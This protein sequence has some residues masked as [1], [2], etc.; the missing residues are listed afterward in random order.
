VTEHSNWGDEAGDEAVSPATE[1]ASPETP[2]EVGELPTL[3]EVLDSLTG[4]DE[5]AIEVIFKSHL[6]A[7]SGIRLF[8]AGAFTLLR[9]QK[10]PDAEAFRTAMA[11]PSREIQAMFRKDEPETDDDADDDAG[12][13]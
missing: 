5:V 9:R 4:F 1:V 3:G 13:A 7:L 2:V 12:K 8:R 11:L 10:I 6:E